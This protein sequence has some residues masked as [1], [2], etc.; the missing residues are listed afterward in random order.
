MPLNAGARYPSYFSNDYE[1]YGVW[2]SL[3]H[4][5]GAHSALC[6]TYGYISTSLSVFLF[7]HYL[8][9]SRQVALSTVHHLFWW[10]RHSQNY[11]N[12]LSFVCFVFF[13]S[14]FVVVGGGVVFLLFFGGLGGGGQ[15]FLCITFL[16]SWILLY[17]AFFSFF[18]FIPF[19]L[20]LS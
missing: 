7:A 20:L 1:R 13:C 19:L 8:L 9:I 17:I 3:G 4:L 15:L 14:V 6:C 11:D 12:R 16:V 5:A 2:R 10:L 18:F